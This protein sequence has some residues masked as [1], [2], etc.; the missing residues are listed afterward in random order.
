MEVWPELEW[1]AHGGVSF[2]PYRDLFN[3]LIPSDKMNYTEIYN[4]S[5]GFFAIQNIRPRARGNGG[6]EWSFEKQASQ[7]PFQFG[8]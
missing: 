6:E 1:Y 7:V 5:E 3:K 8:R 2:E 4:A